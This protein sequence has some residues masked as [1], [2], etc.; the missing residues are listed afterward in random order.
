MT[1]TGKRKFYQRLNVQADNDLKSIAT[2][3]SINLNNIKIGTETHEYAC[4][5][6]NVGLLKF[7][8]AKDYLNSAEF[9][10]NMISGIISDTSK[11]VIQI[12]R[13][14]N[15]I[16]DFSKKSEI[17]IRR[18][19]LKVKNKKQMSINDFANLLNQKAKD[20]QCPDP[21]SPLIL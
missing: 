5:Q 20:L 6:I 4:Q 10:C 11:Q 18:E 21:T 13:G 8:A 1:E 2:L 17:E 14:T 12:C 3:S 19:R 15:A 9:M 7:N 16:A